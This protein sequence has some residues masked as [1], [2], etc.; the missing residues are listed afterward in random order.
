MNTCKECGNDDNVVDELCFNCWHKGHI[1]KVKAQV[2]LFFKL[3]HTAD[4]VIDNMQKHGW[5]AA[6]TNASVDRFTRVIN[7]I[8]DKN[9]MLAN[10]QKLSELGELLIG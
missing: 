1:G 8:G 6:M 2:L 5:F 7:G 10:G 3:Y 4:R 9:R